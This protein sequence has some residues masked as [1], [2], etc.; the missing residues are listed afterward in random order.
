MPP[1]QLGKFGTSSRGTD[2]E[3]KRTEVIPRLSRAQDIIQ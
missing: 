3:T 2:N 1:S